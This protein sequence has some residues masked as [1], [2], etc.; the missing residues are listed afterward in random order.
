MSEYLSLSDLVEI[1]DVESRVCDRGHQFVH[2]GSISNASADELTFCSKSGQKAREALSTTNAEVVV[3]S[4]ENEDR[5]E[6]I[7]QKSLLLVRQPRII[8]GRIVKT[9]FEEPSPAGVSASAE[10]NDGVE[11]G[12]NVY[13]GQNSVIDE[14]VTIGDD[15]T[16]HSN[17]RI[18][19]KTRI[20]DGATIYSGA[21]LGGNGFSFEINEKGESESFPQIGEV[22]IEDD[23]LIGPNTTIMRGTL[24]AT[25]IR[26][27][28]RVNGLCQIGHNVDIG[29]KT[30]VNPLCM[31]AG[32]AK[33]SNS[34]WVSPGATIRQHVE[35]GKNVLV[36]LGAVVT[37]DIDDGV[38]VAG[39]PAHP[40]EVND[41]DLP[42]RPEE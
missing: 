12:D 2:A 9:L 10:V 19:R 14:D 25:H 28:A 41:V 24:D 22:I 8:F 3:T 32:S 39:I 16:I 38:T 7:G 33:I 37:E 6:R 21:V 27:R 36:G 30:V 40:I 17:V 35:I 4:F 23:V 1:I 31:I 13:V 42:I 34:C 11:F 20:G 29:A 26:E 5:C 18:Y 15:V